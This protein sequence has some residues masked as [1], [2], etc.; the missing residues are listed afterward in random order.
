MAKKKKSPFIGILF[1]ILIFVILLNILLYTKASKNQIIEIVEVKGF[2]NIKIYKEENTTIR[3]TEI[4]TNCTKDEDCDWI[5]TNCCKEDAGA[6]WQCLN[7]NSYI[8]CQ[9]KFVLCPNVS[10]PK[11]KEKCKCIN[12]TCEGLIFIVS[13]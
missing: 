13:R 7:K 5:I 4:L 2:G 6:Q 3:P 9:S 1:L 11:P 12:N 10:V 8:D